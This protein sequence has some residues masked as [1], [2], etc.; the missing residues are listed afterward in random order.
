MSYQNLLG[1]VFSP[2]IYLKKN[3]FCNIDRDK[4]LNIVLSINLK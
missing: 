2:L 3:V 1:Y 4:L